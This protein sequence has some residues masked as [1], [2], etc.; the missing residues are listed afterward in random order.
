[1]D[2]VGKK[3]GKYDVIEFI[4][5]GGMASVYKAYQPGVERN[6]AIKVMHQHLATSPDFVQR[7]LREARSAG[8]LHHPHIMPVIDC[9]TEAG[10]HYLVLSYVQGGTL[11]DLLGAQKKLTPEEALQITVQ[12]GEA[13][14]YAHQ[15]GMIHRDIKPANIIFTDDEHQHALLADF[16]IARLQDDVAEGLTA[17]GALIGTPNYM[18]PEAARGEKCD[19]R[20]DIYSLGVVL[21]EM[22][23]GQTPFQADTLYSFLMQ[24]ANEPLPPPRTI[25]PDIPEPIDQLI[26]RSLEKDPNDRFQS[27]SDLVAA[28]QSPPTTSGSSKGAAV[29]SSNGK[30]QNSR[31]TDT[32]SR[33][34]IPL[35][36]VGAGVL[37]IAALT[38]FLLVGLGPETDPAATG[39]SGSQEVTEN[40]AA[41]VGDAGSTDAES[42]DTAST[43]AASTDETEAPSDEET[44]NDVEAAGDE[45][46]ADSDS[47]TPTN[48]GEQEES[49][50]QEVA[51]G[52]SESETSE[53]ETSDAEIGDT[54]TANTDT[55]A[56]AVGDSSDI[57]DTEEGSASAGP[58]PAQL[59]RKIGTLQLYE[60]DETGE[61]AVSIRLAQIPFPAQ[62]SHYELWLG[63]DKDELIRVGPLE[64]ISN[65]VELITTISDAAIDEYAAAL[66]STEPDGDDG[67]APTSVAFSGTLISALE[68]SIPVQPDAILSQMEP[69]DPQVM[70]SELD[71]QMA[72]A[73]QHRGF[74]QEALEEGDL[75]T[76]K[77]H[78]E[79]V[80]NILSGEQGERFGDLN[81]DGIPQNPGNGVG[82]LVYLAQIGAL[83]GDME[84]TASIDSS[85]ISELPLIEEKSQDTL[86]KALQIFAADTADEAQ[87]MSAELDEHLSDLQRMTEIDSQFEGA[88]IDTASQSGPPA[89]P[90]LAF[91]EFHAAF[92]PLPESPT[93]VA[94]PQ[95]VE[96]ASAGAFYLTYGED[97]AS[98]GNG[99]SGEGGSSTGDYGGDGYGGDGYG[100]DS[101][102]DNA[103]SDVSV[104]GN[105]HMAQYEVIL[106]GDPAAAEDTNYHAWMS[107]G[108]GDSLYLGMLQKEGNSWILTSSTD[109]MLL[110]NFEQILITTID[111]NESNGSDLSGVEEVLGQ[112]VYQGK[113]TQSLIELLRRSYVTDELTP[114]GLLW[115]AMEQLELAVAHTG[116]MRSGIEQ[117]DLSEAR[118]HAEHVINILLGDESEF[119]ADLDKDGL[120][121]N[122]GD[123]IGAKR[124]L[125]ALHDSVQTVLQ[126]SAGTPEQ[127]FY[128]ERAL[129]SLQNSLHQLEDS[130]QKALQ[131]FAA[132]TADEAQ[133]F[134]EDL[135]S[136][137][138]QAL[139]GPDLDGDGIAD[140]VQ[141]EGGLAD[142]QLYLT[143]MSQLP[144]TE[145]ID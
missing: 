21:Y 14:T 81:G 5:Q 79:H 107:N 110:E 64:V 50:A 123:G 95:V 34:W 134:Q 105:Q 65:S 111:L 89:K 133:P 142:F 67:E 80:V 122:P 92:T 87:P 124:Y 42:T 7:F 52:T 145:V 94:L 54:E 121:Q 88:L 57:N 33:S 49:S 97:D 86:K 43:D 66:V 77:N 96:I 112:A 125:Q 78:A 4:G 116:F 8:N 28:I 117:E 93:G 76:A 31:A 63:N 135:A 119:G 104:S 15:N 60:Q 139:H 143:L 38:T 39:T 25:N 45:T 102:D 44:A 68:Q 19:E 58:E 114:E 144:L 136:M 30:Q 126:S 17:T 26:L 32:Q 61:D 108:S 18:S 24:Q 35:V 47:D 56:V 16:G 69:I 127:R 138:G 99:S 84:N 115:P 83:A 53:A 113:Y 100:S 27:A 109:Q 23:T 22:V 128:S 140:P 137:L 129:V 51:A 40:A 132:D 12:M 9:D 59:T 1:M 13:L 85:F 131:I 6:V 74:I 118:R 101:S 41:D 3:L 141:D 130:V 11:E 55:D 90:P 46:T 36:A 48:E 20:S 62:G 10:I 120:P 91:F 29:S 71:E 37:L 106:R 70:A 103:N 73:I 82:V 2:L 72:I 75:P 98:D